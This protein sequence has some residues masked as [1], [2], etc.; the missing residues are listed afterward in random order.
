MSFTECMLYFIELP[1]NFP[2]ISKEFFKVAETF[3]ISLAMYKV[4][5]VPILSQT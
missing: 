2:K 3:S 5:F 4:L 1:R